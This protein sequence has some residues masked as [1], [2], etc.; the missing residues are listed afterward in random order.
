MRSIPD[1]VLAHYEGVPQVQRINLSQSDCSAFAKAIAQYRTA[2]NQYEASPE[3]EAIQFYLFN[4]L[5]S[6]V[7]EHFT[8][9]ETLP[10]WATS[11][12]REYKAIMASQGTRLTAYLALITA[13][14][15]RHLSAKS[16]T[17]WAPVI[18]KYG[19]E[20]KQFHLAIKGKSSSYVPQHFVANAPAIPLGNFFK[21]IE[22]IFFKGGFTG[23][24]GGKP[25]GKIAQTLNQFFDGVISQEMLIDTAYTLAHNNGPMFNKGMLYAHYGS[26][27]IPILDVQRAG[28]MPEYVRE[29]ASTSLTA[30]QRA[31][32]YLAHEQCKSEY[33]LYVDWYAVEAAGA[34]GDCTVW[35]M[36][37]DSKYGKQ[38]NKAAPV[39]QQTE[40]NG[41]K[42][43]TTG[44]F[45]IAPN[46]SVPIVE[47]V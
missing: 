4:H 8:R 41:K 42:A 37:Q 14:E 36:K 6:I 12:M 21:V 38:K 15:S 34:V 28:Q 17:W 3:N 24:F 31:I 5:A 45:M 33:G 9:H 7:R 18:E 23:G 19:A 47:R 39:Q 35:K 26:L 30:D 27:L 16:E 25:W 43:V 32:F 40:F 22:H 11:V 46:V 1:N 29:F 13:R 44:E 10:A 2:P 20:T